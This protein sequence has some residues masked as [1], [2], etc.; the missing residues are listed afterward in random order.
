[1][2]VE[3]ENTGS[4]EGYIELPLLHYKGYRAYVTALQDELK[5]EKG[6]NNVVR[7]LLPSGFKGEVEVMFV[8]PIYWRVSEAITYIWWIFIIIWAVCRKYK[9]QRE[10]KNETAV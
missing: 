6:T 10:K 5:T 1:M 4:E 9:N 7:V 3:C 8:S 2:W